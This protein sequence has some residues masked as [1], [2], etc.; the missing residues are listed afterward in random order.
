VLNADNLSDGQKFKIA[1][2]VGYSETAFVCS[3]HDADFNVSFLQQKETF[4]FA[5]MPL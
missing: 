4:I 3:D 1:Q 5:G 2:T